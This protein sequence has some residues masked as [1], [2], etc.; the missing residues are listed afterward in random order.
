MRPTQRSVTARHRKKSF[1]GGWTEET[2]L[3]AMR[4]RALPTA[5]VMERK[6]FKADKTSTVP[7]G[8]ALTSS[9][10]LLV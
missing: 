1:V 7:A 6:M 3:R 9:F 5:A 8:G 4:T 10:S 2:F